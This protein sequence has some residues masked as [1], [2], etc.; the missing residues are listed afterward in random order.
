MQNEARKDNQSSSSSTPLPDLIA[1]LRDLGERWLTARPSSL[2]EVTT[3]NVMRARGADILES[4][5]HLERLAQLEAPVTDTKLWS[6][7]RTALSSTKACEHMKVI[8]GA[9]RYEAAS[10]HLD[11]LAMQLEEAVITAL[12]HKANP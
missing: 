7:I 8:A 1:R 5:T 2:D 4:I 9:E 10:A 11:A 6:P 3:A 12:S